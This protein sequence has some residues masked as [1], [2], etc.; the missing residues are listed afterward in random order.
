MLRADH[1]SRGVLTTVVRRCVL[2]GNLMNEKPIARV[3]PQRQKKKIYFIYFPFSSYL[4]IV[5]RTHSYCTLHVTCSLN[6]LVSDT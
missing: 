1:S 3:G 2:S 5:N 4:I 6:L